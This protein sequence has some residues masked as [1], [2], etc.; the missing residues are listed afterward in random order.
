MKQGKQWL[1]NS[2]ATLL[3]LGLTVG[4]GL[5]CTELGVRFTTRLRNLS[6]DLPFTSHVPLQ[7]L[8]NGR[9]DPIP[10]DLVIVY[11]DD[12]SHQELEQPY[13]RPWDRSQH[14]R[15]I[16]RLTDFGARTIIFD[17]VF[18]DPSPGP[19][20]AAEDQ[21]LADAIERH[22]NVVLAADL[23]RSYQSTGEVP[24]EE[25][26]IPYEPFDLACADIG[27]SQF[28]QDSDLV[29]RRHFHYSEWS[30]LFY[31]L[32]W[33]TAALLGNPITQDDKNRETERWVKYY[34]PVR[35]LPDFSFHEVVK[36]DAVPSEAFKDK[37]V[38]VGAHLV[39]YNSGERKD[40]F[41]N[42]WFDPETTF[43]REDEGAPK[44]MPGVE[45]HSTVLL[46]LLHNDWLQKIS[47][48]KLKTFTVLFGLIAGWIL[49]NLRPLRATL[50]AIAL[51]LGVT[52][53]AFYLHTF[54]QVWF[55]WTIAVAVQ[56]PIALV[57]SVVYN[58]MKL[59]VQKRLLEQSIRAYLSPKLVKAF[60]SRPDENFLKPGAAKQELSILFSDIEG[61]T[62]LSEG[63]DSS[64]LADLMNGYFETTVSSG[65]HA[66]DGTVV[67]YIGDAIFAFWNAPEPQSDHATRAC[68][69]AIEIQKQPYEF[70]EEKPVNTRV[71]IHT[72]VADVGNFG[73]ANRVDYTAIGE[74]INLASRLE[75]LNKY[76]GTRILISVE[77]HEAADDSIVARDLGDFRLKG[78]ERT[79]NVFE[80]I[81]NTDE[82]RATTEARN[83]AFQNI[84][85]QFRKRHFAEAREALDQHLKQWPDDGPAAFY[86]RQCELFEGQTLPEDWDGEIQLDEK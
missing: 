34:G 20:G 22:G 44:F 36:G 13:N 3:C 18:T 29:V 43:F 49:L 8:F 66:T 12:A 62:S 59:F 63:M 48:K 53:T 31:S 32:S 54:K 61:F 40:E 70:S 84:R 28:R 80:L 16:N 72:G 10:D 78:F 24:L 79:V 7:I 81:G 82:T 23:T 77:T 74:N 64:D 42:P 6:Y 57:F 30:E 17:I 1:K 5:A 58:S 39:T 52:G 76:L 14:A 69:A 19:N 37:I 65:I 51:A 55:P 33:S 68:Q 47:E 25:L 26:I 86:R 41:L 4:A 27:F 85:D 60:A 56:L 21:A 50:V 38:F 45:V 2:V 35:T 67:K 71:G 83:A 9:P 46:N 75:G 11:L 73:S 15:L